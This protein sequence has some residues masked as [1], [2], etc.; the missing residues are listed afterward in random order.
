MITFAIGTL[1]H[2]FESVGIPSEVPDASWLCIQ[3][4]L[5][6]LIENEVF[7]CR[8]WIGVFEDND[9]E[10]E[11]YERFEDEEKDLEDDE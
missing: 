6:N 10:E 4:S 2:K 8:L 7:S 9:K 11:N 3:K 5:V 1:F